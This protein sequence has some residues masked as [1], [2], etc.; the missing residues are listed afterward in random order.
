MKTSDVFDIADLKPEALHVVIKTAAH[1]SNL[2]GTLA[3]LCPVPFDQVEKLYLL[4]AWYKPQSGY[5]ASTAAAWARNVHTWGKLL[6]P[7]K[8][9]AAYIMQCM[10]TMLS[11]A[12]HRKPNVQA[13]QDAAKDYH[14]T[15][16]THVPKVT[17]RIY[18][19]ALLYHV[20]DL[21]SLGTLLDGSSW[22]LEAYNKVWKHQLLPT[23]LGGGGGWCMHNLGLQLM[24]EKVKLAMP[25]CKQSALREKT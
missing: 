8:E 12:K 20:P 18:E 4:W 24:S 1:L 11:E 14:Q 15:M 17:L 7:R 5:D 13:F 3:L 16:L 22:F 2:G 23:A 10:S 6:E 19:H 25:G 9:A 21:I